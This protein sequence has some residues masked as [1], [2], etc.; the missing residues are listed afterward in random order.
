VALLVQPEP[1][2]EGALGEE[3][4]WFARHGATEEVADVLNAGKDLQE[5]VLR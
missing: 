5:D 4:S 2:E 3:L 1:T